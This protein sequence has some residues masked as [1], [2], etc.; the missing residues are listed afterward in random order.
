MTS[1]HGRQGDGNQRGRSSR[2]LYF[3]SSRAAASMTLRG[4]APSLGAQS[5]WCSSVLH[6]GGHDRPGL[7]PRQRPGLGP[8]VAY[9]A[10]RIQCEHWL[11]GPWRSAQPQRLRLQLFRLPAKLTTHARETCLQLLRDEPGPGGSATLDE[12][13]DRPMAILREPDTGQVRGFVSKPPDAGSAK[14]CERCRYDDARL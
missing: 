3:M 6:V 2:I 14:P 7:Q 11:C 1:R 5:R 8:F 4:A 9:R 12:N 10:L 13:T